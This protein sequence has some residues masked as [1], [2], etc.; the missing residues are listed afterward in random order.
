MSSPDVELPV[1]D[2]CFPYTNLNRFQLK[3][4]SVH[5]CM[6]LLFDDRSRCCI[7][8]RGSPS[9]EPIKHLHAPPGWVDSFF[10][11]LGPEET[12]TR[13][14]VA[15]QPTPA[16]EK[17]LIRKLESKIQNRPGL[18]PF[19]HILTPP[20]TDSYI[21]F[22]AHGTQAALWTPQPTLLVWR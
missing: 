10:R 16:R 19:F 20:E 6:V 18:S 15:F 12:D 22:L 21:E 7:R 14:G 2:L 1:L 3:P 13:H 5:R 11:T 4:F 9:S 8:T 17:E